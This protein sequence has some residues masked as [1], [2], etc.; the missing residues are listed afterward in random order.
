MLS[1]VQGL[2]PLAGSGVSPGFTLHLPP[3]AA[4]K[5]CTWR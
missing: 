2:P 3:Q 5:A 4:D 1:G